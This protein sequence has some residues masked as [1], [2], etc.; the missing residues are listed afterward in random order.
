MRLSFRVKTILGIAAIEA[1][2]LLVLIWVGLG[3][4]RDA[5]ETELQRRAA[6]STLLFATTTRDAVLAQDLAALDSAVV[7]ALQNPGILYARV[8]DRDG[9]VLA[10]RGAPEFLKRPFRADTG[11]DMVNDGVYDTGADIRIAGVRYG[12]VELG[13]SVDYIRAALAR[14]ARISLAIALVEMALVA[15]FSLLLGTYLT[16]RLAGLRDA[17]LRL[18]AGGLGHQVVV[19]GHDEL[20]ETAHAFNRMSEEM[21]RADRDLR[22]RE[23]AFNEAQRIAHVGHWDWDFAS[24]RQVWSEEARHLFGVP[25]DGEVSRELFLERVHPDDQPRLWAATEA[26]LR[27]EPA[28]DVE[29]RVLRPDGT[30]V[31]IHGRA[32]LRRDAAGNAIGLHGTV[33]D[34]T[35]RKKV[36][37]EMARLSSAI[38]HVADSI[39]ITDRHGVIEFVNPAFESVTGFSAAEAIGRRPDLVK[40]GMH[41]RA[42]YERLWSTILSGQAF[43]DVLT[44]RRKDGTL[45]FEEKSITPIRDE[46][47][48]ITHFVSTGRDIT[49]RVRTQEH[50]HH[51]AYHDALTGLPNRSAFRDR[52]RQ[53]VALA[54]RHRQSLAVLFIDLDRF[55]EIN[56]DLG[57]AIGD[58]LLREVAERLH[59][60]LRVAD[61][62]ARLGGDEF[63]VILESAGQRDEIER[64]AAKLL[65]ALAVPIV[66]DGHPLKVTASL[67][68]AVFPDDAADDGDLL[69][70]ADTAMYR[71]KRSGRDQLCF[72]SDEDPGAHDQAGRRTMK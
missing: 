48:Q 71:A 35:E 5:S 27:G 69:K 23:H 40:S 60:G 58:G 72:Y 70:K 24:Q 65:A 22:E 50:L 8:R 4:M 16:R 31:S 1:I 68:A 62:V 36:E 46:Y 25:T 18:R 56:D 29:Y 37:A 33:Q 66:V 38:R 7:A 3:F 20:A 11:I 13:L 17:A 21:A 61:T 30:V 57:H 9:R 10:A 6:T 32:R 45:Y 15:L 63:A 55:K 59:S 47:G 53:A 28:G 12:R 43:R 42:F 19:R 39:F 51:L 14:T 26:A 52:L 67:G 44:N 54:G 49:E 2:M 34:V 41:D 64:V